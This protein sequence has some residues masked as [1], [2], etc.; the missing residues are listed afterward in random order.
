MNTIRL[1][2]IIVSSRVSEKATT[3]ADFEE[4]SMCFSFERCDQA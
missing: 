1:A 2:N 3:R 4:S